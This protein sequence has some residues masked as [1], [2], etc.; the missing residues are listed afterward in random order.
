MNAKKLISIPALLLCG[1]ILTSCNVGNQKIT[2]IEYWKSDSLSSETVKEKL[3]YDVVVENLSK[4]AF[5]NYQNGVYTSELT[6]ATQNDTIVYTLKTSLTIEAVY[7]Y[8]EES[9]T[10][11]DSVSSETVFDR[12]LAP[13]SSHKEIVCNTPT[14]P[15]LEISKLSDCYTYFKSVSD[16]AYEGNKAVTS[17]YLET[18]D[19]NG[20]I[21][22]STQTPSVE[23]DDKK[24]TYLDNEQ[25]LLSLRGIDPAS[26]SSGKVLAYSPFVS[27]VQTIKFNY[28][29]QT[30]GE[31]SFTKNGT[32]L[33]Q[34]TIQY[35]PVTLQIDA[36]N[37]GNAQT[38]WIAKATSAGKNTYRNVMLR[39]QSPISY[40]IGTLVYTLK[41]AEF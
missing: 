14:N 25:L 35:Y 3:V 39:L 4:D 30:G 21:R 5:V 16:I 8:G 2:F 32:A 33:S 19:D 37:S 28:G 41:T 20:E 6:S 22:S 34:E 10:F 23:I 38:V 24:Y 40:G 31:F 29:S 12:A 26:T 7:T 1:A 11:Q 18:K 9:V 36:K 15:S 13:I 27:A 17:L